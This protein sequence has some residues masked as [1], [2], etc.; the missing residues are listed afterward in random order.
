MSDKNLDVRM[1]FIDE[2]SKGFSG[3]ISALNKGTK[4]AERSWK[5]V[6]KGGKQIASVGDKLTTSVT[7]PIAGAA[8]V[9]VNKYAEVDKTMALTNATM[10]NSEAEAKQLSDAMKSAAANSTFGMNDAA[11]AALNFARAGLSAEEASNALAPAMNLAAGEGG[12]LDTVSSGLVAT[13][14]GFHGS[15]DEAGK[16]ADVFAAACSNSALDI[17]SLSESMSTATPIFAAAGYGVED[18]ALAMGVMANG[19]IDANVAANSLK[20]GLARLTSPAKDGAAAL[21]SLGYSSGSAADNTEKLT[22]AQNKL[23]NANATLNAKRIKYNEAVAKY[24]ET[25]SQAAEAQAALTKATNS[26]EEAQNAVNILT[27]AATEG[28]GAYAQLMVDAEGNM[29]PFEDVLK[30][31]QTSFSGLSEQEQISAA[32]A[33]FGKNQMAPWLTMINSSPDKVEALSQSLHNASGTTD[34]MSQAMM[35]GFGGSIEKLK[36]SIDV[37]MTTLGEVA[38]KYLTPIIGKIQEFADKLNSLSPAE[39]DQI[40]KMLA[41][42]ASVGPVISVFGRAVSVIGK[43]GG[44]V[45]HIKRL[46]T[47]AMGGAKALKGLTGG[48]KLLKVGVAALTSPLGLAIVAVAGLIAVVVAIKTH[49]TQFKQSL[50]AS[51]PALNN[52][53]KSL[54][55]L[56][57]ALGPVI[58]VV[59][60][61]GKVI[62]DIFSGVVISAIGSAVA[63]VANAINL[64]I[65]GVTRV[66]NV[67]KDVVKL[68]KAIFEGDWAT[69]FQAAGDIVNNIFGGIKDMIEGVVG[70]VKDVAGAIKGAFTGLFGGKKEK[71]ATTPA[72]AKGGVV[73]DSLGYNQARAIIPGRK[74]GDKSWSGG[75]VQ[76]HERG[77]EIM[78]LPGG[79]RIYPHD[80][81]VIMAKSEG[82]KSASKSFN[83]AKLAD[84][85]IVRE[86]ADIDKIVDALV[87]KLE[88]ADANYAGAY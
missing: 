83:I 18:A 73:P 15:F 30:D 20:T 78:D 70:T 46:A 59:Q 19:G 63:V 4:A 41:L 52:I 64:I 7:L 5:S 62:F 66:V 24:G 51:R 42:A 3:T 49:F 33:I 69:A 65:K 36:S 26:Q 81:S 13:I 31:L 43:I 82:R 34:Q 27:S 53:R 74:S 39:Q 28:T 85:I 77:G 67:I 12:N 2:F 84:S 47:A 44:T 25:S 45:T 35:S 8:T 60:Q 17:D 29:R 68:I 38:A 56:E 54:G 1:R 75:L 16:Y 86:D 37:L 22:K 79:T 88:L 14:N 61:V 23:E 72:Y 50:N 10:K 40:V 21:E 48:A 6:E 57:T 9:A 11:T 80:K 58:P 71:A 87:R 55:Q 76:V 32:S